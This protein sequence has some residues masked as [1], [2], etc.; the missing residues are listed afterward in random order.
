MTITYGRD[1]NPADAHVTL[2]NRSTA[3]TPNA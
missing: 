1:G 3:V 2:G